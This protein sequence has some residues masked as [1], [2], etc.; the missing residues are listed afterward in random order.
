[1]RSILVK[2]VADYITKD[3][4]EL[5]FERQ[6]IG[7]GDIVFSEIDEKKGEAVVE[8]KRGRG[9]YSCINLCFIKIKLKKQLPKQLP[10]FCMCKRIVLIL[11][12]QAS[13]RLEHHRTWFQPLVANCFATDRSK[14][15]TPRVIFFVYCLWCL[16]WN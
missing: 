4:I 7:G 8:F 9:K 5:Y 10:V 12:T 11:S 1:M 16:F 14:A 15:V 13:V 2:G 6:E 3:T